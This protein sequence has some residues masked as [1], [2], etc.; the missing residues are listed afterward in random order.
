MGSNY[1]DYARHDLA[2]VSSIHMVISTPQ[3]YISRQ[4]VVPCAGAE[5][6]DNVGMDTSYEAVRDRIHEAFRYAKKTKADIARHCGV[7][8]TAV[9]NWFNNGKV[10]RER[11]VPLAQ[12]LECNTDWLIAG[13]GPRAR[14]G[15]REHMAL[16]ERSL[17]LV[18]SRAKENRVDLTTVPPEKVVS[19]VTMIY[20]ILLQ[21]SEE[22]ADAAQRFMRSVINSLLHAEGVGSDQDGRVA[23]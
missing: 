9:N 11:V 15:G 6:P 21:S 13:V 10:S 4:Y 7:K 18:L 8:P 14:W 1:F 22:D 16:I 17:M 2:L 19:I 3:I 12:A 23:P 20:E 5:V